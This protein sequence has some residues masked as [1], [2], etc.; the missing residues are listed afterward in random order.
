MAEKTSIYQLLPPA[1]GRIVS[2]S[3]HITVT[4]K[5][6]KK[7]KRV[8]DSYDEFISRLTHT[9]TLMKRNRVEFTITNIAEWYGVHRSTLYD[10][11]THYG[12][13]L[14]AFMHEFLGL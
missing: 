5:E 7:R 6:P 13:N 1:K 3:A 10:T 11:A 9:L 14:K 12:V 2:L 8:F 4:E